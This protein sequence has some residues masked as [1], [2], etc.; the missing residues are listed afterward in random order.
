MIDLYP[1]ID[2]GYSEYGASMGRSAWRGHPEGKVTLYKLPIDQGGY[3]P[4][5]AYWGGP[6]NIY[7]AVDEGGQFRYF[8]RA[9]D[10]DEARR[11]IWDNAY[12]GPLE[13]DAALTML[14]GYL[15]AALW[16]ERADDSE[17]ASDESFRD[18][19]YS[20]AQVNEVSLREAEKD[21]R[22]FLVQASEILPENPDYDGL[23]HCFWMSR[24]GH[25]TGFGDY[26]EQWGGRDNARKLS[27]LAYGFSEKYPYLND[28]DEVVL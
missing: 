19:N 8:T 15:T 12:Q 24:Q 7:Y 4:G 23:G 18:L 6:D 28:N 14:G 2:K 17:D 3:D 26:S 16:A 20:I 21:C 5:G 13:L 11:H 22:E 10:I 27:D 1:T 25:G 9:K